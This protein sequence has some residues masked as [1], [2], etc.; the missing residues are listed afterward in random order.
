MQRGTA[1]PVRSWLLLE[2]PGAW[3]RAALAEALAGALGPADRRRLGVLQRERLLR[4]L[5]IRRPGRT[6]DHDG[7]RTLLVGSAVPGAA[8]LERL[9]VPDL[10]ALAGLDL[11]ALAAGRPGHGDPVDGPALLVCTHGAKD[12]CCAVEGRP[13][14][15]A[16]AAAYG[17]RV[18]ECSH[19]GGDRFAG[20]L[21]VAPHGEYHGH[22]DTSA[23]L[24]VAAA[25]VAGR[26]ELDGFRGRSSYDPW[27]QAAEH[28]VRVRTGLLG[29]D[30]VACG[31]AR[32]DGGRVHVAVATP[33]GRFDVELERRVQG[34]VAASRCRG[35]VQ[36]ADHAVVGLTRL[37]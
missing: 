29:R 26:I 6:P 19:V 25:A 34:W 12:M 30:E 3:S 5:L 28:A 16:L 2:Q 15:R 36:P 27:Q 7:P 23:A 18:W 33:R 8:W 32:E 37:A 13:I 21:V 24:A 17:D 20:N 31:P 14:A 11:E 9:V 10:R 4:A 35:G 1:A 22:L